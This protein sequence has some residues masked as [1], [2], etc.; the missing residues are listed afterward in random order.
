MRTFDE[1]ETLWAT[2]PAP[3]RE[4]GT[5]RLVCRRV[6][7]GVHETPAEAELSVEAGLVGDR[8]SAAKDPDR[9]AQVT[10]MNATVAPSGEI[11]GE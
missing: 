3:P 2:V 11:R 10:L 6:E 8:W 9:E 4:R 7:P 1:L 5:L